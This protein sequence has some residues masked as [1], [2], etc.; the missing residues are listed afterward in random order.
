[1]TLSFPESTRPSSAS[2]DDGFVGSKRAQPT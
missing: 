2:S 1:M